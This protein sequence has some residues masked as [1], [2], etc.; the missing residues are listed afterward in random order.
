M[1]KNEEISENECNLAENQEMKK[2]PPLDAKQLI[3]NPFS[4]ELVIPATKIVESDKFVKD[5]DGVMLPSS[6]VVD[7][8]KYTRVIRNAK[9]RQMMMTLSPTAL[10]LLM[11]II[12]DIEDANDWI[13]VMPEFYAKNGGKGASR[14]QYK[15]A[16][17]ELMDSGYITPT[18]FKY[19]YW[20]N[21]AVIYPGSRVN[22]YPDKVVIKNTWAPNKKDE[23]EPIEKL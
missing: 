12:E 17:N 19:T 21:P 5:E 9:F 23:Q 11:W 7:K 14:T 10:K 8:E 22:K 3:N 15:V 2:Y 18:K 20:V 4:Q 16:V 1:N 6:A 13:R